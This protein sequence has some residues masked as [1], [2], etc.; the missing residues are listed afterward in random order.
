MADFARFAS[1]A[2]PA[3]GAGEGVFLSAYEGKLAQGHAL[4]LE[5]SP[6][7]EPIQQI[8]KTGFSG[9]ATDLLTRLTEIAG[10]EVVRRKTWPATPRLLSTHLRK[11]APNL[12]ATG[13]K[14]EFEAPGFRRGIEIGKAAHSSVRSVGSDQEQADDDVQPDAERTQPTSMDAADSDSRPRLDGHQDA[15]DA[16]DAR[17][18]ASRKLK[19]ELRAREPEGN[20]AEELNGP[21][22]DDDLSFYGTA[23]FAALRRK[24]ECGE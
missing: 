8:A 24:H 2:E 19:P 1:A 20:L 12:R 18:E 10:D 21:L 14:I 4:A 13:I 5:G 6:L 23:N 11:L 22:N 3:F 16:T 7:T 9:T 15:T 17:S